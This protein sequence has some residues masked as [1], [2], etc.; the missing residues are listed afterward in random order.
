MPVKTQAVC[1]MRAWEPSLLGP[2]ISERINCL[3]AEPCPNTATNKTMIPSPP[4]KWVL[5]RQKRMQ[6]GT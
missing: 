4:R 1:C 2:G 5:L 6:R 3:P